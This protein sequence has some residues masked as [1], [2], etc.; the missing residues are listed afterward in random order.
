MSSGFRHDSFWGFLNLFKVKGRKT[1]LE[2][3]D[4]PPWPVIHGDP[5]AVDVLDNLN[6]AD[7][8]AWA[9]FTCVGKPIL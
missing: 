1:A 9:F 7:L 8:G 3:G 5:D 4:R 2:A 6:A